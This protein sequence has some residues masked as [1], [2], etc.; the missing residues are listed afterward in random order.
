MGGPG[1]PET[2][3][4]ENGAEFDDAVA[5]ATWPMELRETNRG[6]RLRY[7]RDGRPCQIPL[8]ALRL[9]DHARHVFVAGRCI[10]CS[11]E[12]QASHPRHRHL[13]R[14]RRSRGTGAVAVMQP[15]HLSPM[16]PCDPA[17]ASQRS[18]PEACLT[19]MNIV[20]RIFERADRSAVAL[21]CGD[22]H[23]TFGD[24]FE[25]AD[26]AAARIAKAPARRIALDCPN[27]VAHVV[28]ALAIVRAG[29]C[30]VPIASELGAHAS[31]IA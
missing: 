5:L 23:I 7:P 11:H 26:A 3:D 15:R 25:R 2:D 4:L 16:G 21:I 20:S 30:L 8:R 6:P 10:S 9:R 29:K 12:A 31:A 27:G 18:G 28:L 17:E 19:T 13:P 1:L 24:L 22:E 14:H